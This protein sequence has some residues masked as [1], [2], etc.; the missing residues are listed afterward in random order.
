MTSPFGCFIFHSSASLAVN[1]LVT[2]AFRALESIRSSLIFEP[3]RSQ[4]S[5]ELL[6]IDSDAF[7]ALE[8]IRSSLIFEPPR[9]QVSSEPVRIDVQRSGLEL[10][11]GPVFL[12]N[13]PYERLHLDPITDLFLTMKVGGV[14]HA[15]LEATAPWGL[16]RD[17]SDEEGTAKHSAQSGFSPPRFA[18]F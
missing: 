1:C 16:K 11:C 4:V 18:H 2:D 15:R 14:V 12:S 5:S 17:E 9:S 10:S 7:R 13:S 6:R 3:P 8:S